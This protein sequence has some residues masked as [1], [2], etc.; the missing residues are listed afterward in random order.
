MLE[1]GHK[2]LRHRGIKA[3]YTA[4]EDKSF[5]RGV[6]ALIQVNIE[7]HFVVW[8]CKIFL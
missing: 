6:S 8:Y 1:T 2:Y 3:F 7:F 5:S 4:V